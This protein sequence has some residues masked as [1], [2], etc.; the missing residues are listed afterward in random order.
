MIE[1][2]LIVNTNSYHETIGPTLTGSY[3][4]CTDSRI[5]KSGDIFVALYGPSFNGTEFVE[6]AFEKGA[7]AAIISKSSFTKSIE[8]DLSVKY[9]RPI[10]IV[11]D[12]YQFIAELAVLRLHQWKSNGGIVVGLTGSNGKTTHKELLKALFSSCLG[13]KHVHVTKGN[14]NNHIGVP[15]TIFGINEQHKVAVI[16]MGTNHPGEIKT[17]CEIALPDHG[18]ITNIGQSHLQFLKNE[19][20]VFEEKRT[21][22]DYVKNINEEG[23]FVVNADDPY[24]DKLVGLENLI[25]WKAD[26]FPYFVK[27]THKSLTFKL[28]NNTHIVKNPNLYGEH[29]FK[30]LMNCLL[31][32]ISLFPECEKSIL[33]S[34]RTLELPRNNRSCWTKFKGLE[35]FLDAYNANP[36][37]MEAGLL[38]FAAELNAKNAV[39]DKVLV[40]LGDMNELGD[41][42]EQYHI[43]IGQLVK[44]L[45]FLNAIFIG[46]YASHYKDGYGEGVKIFD[47]AD[48]LIPDFARLTKKY[49]HIFIK[50]SRALQLERLLD[51][52]DN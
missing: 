37:S 45:G 48:E 42:S 28:H 19:N 39:M 23:F 6:K 11:S 50:G 46:R 44:K 30:N 14:L 4:I 51:I 13:E 9:N 43:K 3:N 25:K 47:C 29:N 41:L 26:E 16:E 24:L 8:D 17:L 7:C 40:I 21:L 15:L 12:T 10:I 1:A 27:I 34:A 35:V 18:L 36:A 38:Y 52:N 20:G 22:F 2:E 32:A 49:T 5:L 33:H 31:L